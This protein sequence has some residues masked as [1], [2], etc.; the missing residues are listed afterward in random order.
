MSTNLFSWAT[1]SIRPVGRH[2]VWLA[3]AT[4][5]ADG[6]VERPGTRYD[7]P[8]SAAATGTTIAATR[9]RHLCGDPAVELPATALV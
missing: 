4:G 1:V 2:R 5:G 8:S 3:P 9:S 6:G 7:A